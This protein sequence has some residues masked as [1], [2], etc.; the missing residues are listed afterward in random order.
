MD[1]EKIV[2]R[3]TTL[4]NRISSALLDETFII[5][6]ALISACTWIQFN[7]IKKNLQK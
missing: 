7:C 1:I 4:S 3:A 6:F 5:S 2:V